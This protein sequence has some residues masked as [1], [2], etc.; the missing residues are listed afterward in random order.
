VL[1]PD[2]IFHKVQVEK[3]T[4]IVHNG[5]KKLTLRAGEGGNMHHVNVD[6]GAQRTTREGTVSPG[7][8]GLTG[9]NVQRRHNI[10]QTRILEQK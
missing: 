3:S 4:Y 5:Y 1:Q 6:D 7:A 9:V 10:L 2:L 8:A